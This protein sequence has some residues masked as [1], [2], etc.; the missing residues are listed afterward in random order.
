ML[1][2][3]G[4]I[5][6]VLSEQLSTYMKQLSSNQF[7]SF[8]FIQITSRKKRQLIIRPFPH[9][10][11][12]CSFQPSA[13]AAATVIRRLQGSAGLQQQCHHLA[14]AFLGRHQQRRQTSAGHGGCRTN[15]ANGLGVLKGLPS[16]SWID[17][18]GPV[19]VSALLFKN[20]QNSFYIMSFARWLNHCLSCQLLQ[21]Q[22]LL[23]HQTLTSA[24][25]RFPK[26]G[27]QTIQSQAAVH[28]QV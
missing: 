14:V 4:R 7:P 1:I 23:P 15:L 10:S 27:K 11:P 17:I 8:C 2:K 26:R 9:P 20:V 6:F 5:E 24:Y 22:A 25:K 3:C 12:G 28:C 16:V 19:I 18:G 21:C 13:E